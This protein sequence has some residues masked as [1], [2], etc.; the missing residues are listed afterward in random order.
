M[1][2]RCKSQTVTKSHI[3]RSR[4]RRPGRGLSEVLSEVLPCGRG[5][6]LSEEGQRSPPRAAAGWDRML[7]CF[8]PVDA[9]LCVRGGPSVMTGKCTM[10]VFYPAVDARGWQGREVQHSLAS[11]FAD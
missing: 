3:P 9:L 7:A 6:A 8:G 1:P 5:L 2:P 11:F 10:P 4:A